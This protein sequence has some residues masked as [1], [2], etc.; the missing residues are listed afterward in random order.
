VSEPSSYRHGAPR[1][2]HKIERSQTDRLLQRVADLQTRVAEKAVATT[3]LADRLNDITAGL[4]R[5]VRIGCRLADTAANL[6]AARA[7][8]SAATPVGAACARKPVPRF[9]V[10]SLDEGAARP[11]HWYSHPLTLVLP[12]AQVETM[13][14][15]AQRWSIMAGGRFGASDSAITIWSGP[16]QQRSVGAS[17]PAIIGYAA[18]EWDT[19]VQQEATISDIAWRPAAGGSAALVWRLLEL[20]A[21][22]PLEAAR[23]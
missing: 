23:S 14:D 10:S 19:P 3:I 9:A 6:H 18:V 16:R 4:T 12:Q 17:R 15:R 11:Q 1:V 8:T 13:W 7:Q 22:T 2:V 21:G 5:Q 20:L